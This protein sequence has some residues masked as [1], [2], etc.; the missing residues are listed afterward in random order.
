MH[1]SG[2]SNPYYCMAGQVCTVFLLIKWLRVECWVGLIVASPRIYRGAGPTCSWVRCRLDNLCLRTQVSH[3]C[4][5][6]PLIIIHPSNK[7]TPWFEALTAATSEQVNTKQMN[8]IN[9]VGKGQFMHGRVLERNM[10]WS[11]DYQVLKSKHL[12]QQ[13]ETRQLSVAAHYIWG[14]IITSIMTMLTLRT[15][16]I[17]KTF[18]RKYVC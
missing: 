17:T 14:I 16:Q 11:I 6:F 8:N 13:C 5:N 1:T 18:V 15:N 10:T 3:A 9:G 12:I 7:S 4:S 2:D